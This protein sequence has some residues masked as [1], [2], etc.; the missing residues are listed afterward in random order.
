VSPGLKSYVWEQDTNTPRRDLFDG[1]NTI[2]YVNTATCHNHDPN[3]PGVVEKRRGYR[4]GEVKHVT[5]TLK[6][7]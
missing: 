5:L 6:V 4:P 7:T 2:A 3:G 1:S